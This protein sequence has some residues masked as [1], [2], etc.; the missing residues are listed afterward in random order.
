MPRRVSEKDKKN[1]QFHFL[2][3]KDQKKRIEEL[4]KA[5]ELTPADYVRLTALQ[6]I[7]ISKDTINTIKED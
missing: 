1:V 5:A 7:K 4:A 6:K 3:S 2:V